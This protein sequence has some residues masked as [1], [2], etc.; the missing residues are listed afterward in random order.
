MKLQ[1]L[2]T[3]QSAKCFVSSSV[4]PTRRECGEWREQRD[5]RR[6]ALS[7][8][9]DSMTL[10]CALG[11]RTT[12]RRRRGVDCRRSPTRCTLAGV[13]RDTGEGTWRDCSERALRL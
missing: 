6:W 12:L 2:H 5:G 7:S 11:M 10:F 1:G 3:Y 4:L 8:R 9:S 13:P